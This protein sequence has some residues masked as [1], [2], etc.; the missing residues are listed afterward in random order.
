MGNAAS[1]LGNCCHG[2]A[3]RIERDTCW[4]KTVYVLGQEDKG[5][6][7]CDLQRRPSIYWLETKV[8]SL[9]VRAYPRAFLRG[10]FPA[11]SEPRRTACGK[12]DHE[13]RCPARMC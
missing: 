4:V 2:D 7:G 3:H 11:G 5:N 10:R 1:L 6:C 9:S 12:G 13:T 8:G